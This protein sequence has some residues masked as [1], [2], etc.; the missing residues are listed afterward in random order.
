[1]NEAQTS[2][3]LFP[4]QSRWARP[5]EETLLQRL[6]RAEMLVQEQKAFLRLQEAKAKAAEM[7][8]A[9]DAARAIP[10]RSAIQPHAL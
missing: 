1:M 9:L 5:P 8:D 4:A 6:Q 7:Q 3:D 10:L 2:R